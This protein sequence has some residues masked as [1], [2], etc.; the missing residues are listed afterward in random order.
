MNVTFV[1]LTTAAR[2]EQIPWAVVTRGCEPEHMGPK[3][4]SSGRET[5]ALNC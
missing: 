3:L 4:G 5:S 2:R 1:W